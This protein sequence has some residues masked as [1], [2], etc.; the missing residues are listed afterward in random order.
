MNFFF[1][2]CLENIAEESDRNFEDPSI[3]D[4]PAVIA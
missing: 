1:N 2:L 3:L 4:V